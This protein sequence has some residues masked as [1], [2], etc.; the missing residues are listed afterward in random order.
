[1]CRTRRDDVEMT[2]AGRDAHGTWYLG[3]GVGRGVWW[4]VGQP[5]E[6]EL[7][8]NHVARALRTTVF[9]SD[10]AALRGLATKKSP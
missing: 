4:C 8:V 9:E 10:V 6:Q 1:M 2:R 3:R 5:C 7:R